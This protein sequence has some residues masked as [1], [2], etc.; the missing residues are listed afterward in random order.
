M[1]KIE[2]LEQEY[3]FQRSL[4]KDEVKEYDRELTEEKLVEIVIDCVPDWCNEAAELA[5]EVSRQ[6][7]GTFCGLEVPKHRRRVKETR[8]PDKSVKEPS[9]RQFK[10]QLVK[11]YVRATKS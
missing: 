6:Q 10:A 11:L 5:R 1:D 4:P 2:K 7:T 3:N 9:Y 8:H